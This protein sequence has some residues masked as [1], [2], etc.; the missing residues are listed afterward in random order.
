VSIPSPNVTKPVPPVPIFTALVAPR[1][2][3]TDEETLKKEKKQVILLKNI[4]NNTTDP[5]YA[6]TDSVETSVLTTSTLVSSGGIAALSDSA[7]VDPDTPFPALSPDEP[8]SGVHSASSTNSEAF[9]PALPATS[10]AEPD[11]NEPIAAEPALNEPST[12]EPATLPTMPPALTPAQALLRAAKLDITINVNRVDTGLPEELVKIMCK[13]CDRNGS[14]RFDKTA[15]VIIDFIVHF[16]KTKLPCPKCGSAHL[17]VRHGQS[18][19]RRKNCQASIGQ[20]FLELPLIVIRRLSKLFLDSAYPAMIRWLKT[21]KS[22]NRTQVLEFLCSIQA[23]NFADFDFFKPLPRPMQGIVATTETNRPPELDSSFDDFLQD[24]LQEGMLTAPTP[25]VSPL[26]T[27]TETAMQIVEQA[28]APTTTTTQDD[29]N[30]SALI[31]E[32]RHY[33][34]RVRELEE[35]NARL[36]LE[37]AAA[38]AAAKQQAPPRSPSLSFSQIASIPPLPQPNKPASHSATAPTASAANSN[39]KRQRAEQ[40]QQPVIRPEVDFRNFIPSTPKPAPAPPRVSSMGFVFV[41]GLSRAPQSH[42]RALLEQLGFASSKARDILFLCDDFLQILTYDDCKA[43]LAA[44]LLDK[45]GDA[46]QVYDDI[47]P[48]DPLYYTVLGSISRE[49]IEA[50]YFAAIEA[51]VRRFRVLVQSNP[52]LT[53]TLRFLEKVLLTRN[54]KYQQVSPV[55]KVYFMSKL[56]QLDAL[57]NSSASSS[58]MNVTI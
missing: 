23:L 4:E 15:N 20:L 31:E 56:I 54:I 28:P 53:R 22:A 52:G 36:T 14:N 1:L 3:V 44:K 37:L 19:F 38:K 27:T 21:Y 42:Y 26:P 33:R 47:D 2:Q 12:A 8:I 7:P 25:D 10:A 58:A 43:D 32:L 41:K 9:E 17:F 24:G 40:Q 34:T 6:A 46:I 48:C 5:L 18:D 49:T 16:H 45:F 35:D 11:A 29:F 51:S 55:Q 57:T 13:W 39:A 30:Y 50:S